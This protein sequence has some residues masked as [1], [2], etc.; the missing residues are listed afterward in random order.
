MW[1]LIS[2]AGGLICGLISFLS[3]KKTKNHKILMA[4]VLPIVLTISTSVISFEIAAALAKCDSPDCG[5]LIFVGASMFGTIIAL[6]VAG[7]SAIGAL[8]AYRGR[9]L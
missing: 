5:P 1:I 4:I 6:F 8:Y 9:P 2:T 3:V 7:G